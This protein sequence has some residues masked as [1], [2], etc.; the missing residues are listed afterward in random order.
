MNTE[1]DGHWSRREFLKT[2]AL[3]G[4]G[5]LFGSHSDLAAAEAP[6]ETKRIRL[7]SIPGVCVAPQYVSEELL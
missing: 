4:S 1:P 6:P 3:A 5:A 2:A 7:V